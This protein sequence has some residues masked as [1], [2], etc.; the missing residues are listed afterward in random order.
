MAQ[1][2]AFFLLPSRS[3][4]SSFSISPRAWFRC[5]SSTPDFIRPPGPVA[6]WTRDEYNAYRRWRYATDADYRQARIQA[7][8]EFSK[9]DP[10]WREKKIKLWTGWN[11]AH[12]EVRAARD[13]RLKERYAD[14][15]EYRESALLQRGKERHANDAE[16]RETKLQR[17]KER[18]A[19][20]PE[21]REALRQRK[22]E[23]YADPAYR[24]ASARRSKDRYANDPVYRENV[25]QRTRERY[26]RKKA[27]QDT[28][29]PQET[30]DLQKT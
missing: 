20:D 11:L 28:S 1:V 29:S 30:P 7:A 21:Y 14:D 6:S 18:Y 25:K 22:A 24:E 15:P 26:L 13:Q 27:D 10:V 3:I 9:N 5:S 23:R 2:M 16:F 4:T 8:C 12:P 17:N 19:N